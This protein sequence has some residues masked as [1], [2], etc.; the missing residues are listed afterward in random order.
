MKQKTLFVSKIKNEHGITLTDDDYT[1][2]KKK[3]NKSIR[4]SLIGVLIGVAILLFIVVGILLNELPFNEMTFLPLGVVACMIITSGNSLT[5]KMNQSEQEFIE[6]LKT[7]YGS[8]TP[9][10]PISITPNHNSRPIASQSASKQPKL[11][12]NCP[13]CH[14]LIPVNSNPCPKCGSKLLWD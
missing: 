11:A 12:E 13:I 10:I 1:E 9:N 4:S 2:Y 7:K 14:Q 3:A 6:Y 8:T 5:K